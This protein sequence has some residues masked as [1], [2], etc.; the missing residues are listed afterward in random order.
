MNRIASTRSA[1]KLRIERVGLVV[2]MALATINIWTGGP[3]FALW[4][5]SRVQGDGPPKM[6]AVFVVALVLGAVSLVLVRV[7]AALDAVYGR[8]SGRSTRVRQHV[9]WLRSMRGERP[10]EHDREVALSALEIVLVAS[11]V[12]V[13]VL[14]EI[15]FFFFSSSPIDG[16]SGR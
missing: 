14:F 1:V 16:R 8:I 4:C 5:G 6:S 15:W 9:P 3:L 11:V 2:A 7:L 13:V 12:L 10:H